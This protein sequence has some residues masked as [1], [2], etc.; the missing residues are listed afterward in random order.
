MSKYL[1][2]FV[3]GM[4]FGVVQLVP[5]VSGGTIAIIM[6]FYYNLIE[7][8]NHFR[9]E[10]RKHLTFLMPLLAGI[11]AGMLIF[12]SVISFLLEYYAFPTMLFF[13]GLI[14]GI[15]P[16]IYL[17]IKP[18]NRRFSVKEALLVIV[19]IL[20]LVVISSFGSASP[21]SPT[22]VIEE[23][24]LMYMLFLF[25]AGA[26]AAASL[27]VPGISGSFVL[28]L[29]G[30]YHV[31]TYSISS[32]R[33]WLS[34]MSNW[35]LFLDIC[36][37]LGPLGIGIVIGGLLMARLIE[38][39]LNNHHNTVYSIILGLMVGSVYSLANEPI[40]LHSGISPVIITFGIVA[41]FTGCFVSYKIGKKK[42]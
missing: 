26:L 2:N 12:G 10:P 14:V 5:G 27:V 20:F 35:T 15:I 25:I 41:F 9:K 11:A 28:L 8:V 39:L 23:I 42:L 24:N 21:T 13:I 7:A 18:E 32:I 6:G 37:V 17:K 40:V 1:R 19:P 38:N 29:F 3:N 31:A 16:L 22:A 33:H 36:K 34:D 30:V 4:V